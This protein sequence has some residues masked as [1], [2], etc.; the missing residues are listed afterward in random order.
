MAP[1]KPQP[2]SDST[3]NIGRE[4]LPLVINL[5]RLLKPPAS[6]SVAGFSFKVYL[7]TP[8]V[9]ERIKDSVNPSVIYILEKAT[10]LR[11]KWRALTNTD[12]PYWDSI[13]VVSSINSG[14]QLLLRESVNHD[15]RSEN[16]QVPVNDLT[17]ETLRKKVE[18]LPENS[19]LALYSTCTLNDDSTAHI[20][21]M[22]FRG[23]PS[24]EQLDKVKTALKAI[25]QTQGVI[26]TSGRSYH[27]YGFTLLG[28]KEWM[29]FMGRCLLIA[30]LT[31]SRYIA[32]RLIEG[33]GAL[34]VTR[35]PLKPEIPSVVEVL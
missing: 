2:P 27:F 8:P 7:P 25:H 14:N 10:E 34:R 32:H 20:P 12:L 23:A 21:M 33:A 30:P 18:S 1:E 6:K 13:A 15:A 3:I 4:A 11:E 28:H 19:V 9:E 29:E 31:D 26:L 24:P 5:P 16:F 35:S 17:M 22:D